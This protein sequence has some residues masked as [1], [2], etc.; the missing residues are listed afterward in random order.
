MAV[1]HFFRTSEWVFLHSHPNNYLRSPPLQSPAQSPPQF[2]PG[3]RIQKGQVLQRLPPEIVYKTT[4]ELTERAYNLP[5]NTLSR[6]NSPPASSPSTSPISSAQAGGPED[7]SSPRVASLPRSSGEENPPHTPSTE[8][9]PANP[10][11]VV[12]HGAGSPS[13]LSD[14]RG[15]SLATS[16]HSLPR[17]AEAP[18]S[19]AVNE[20]GKEIVVSCEG[21]DGATMCG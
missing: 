13:N 10:I 5:V 21:V 17:A 7:S 19:R 4:Y 15:A 9:S 3:E 18:E 12:P 20:K 2:V 6:G 8:L 11:Q 1:V 16:E 14:P